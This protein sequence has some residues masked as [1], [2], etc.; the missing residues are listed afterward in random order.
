MSLQH[1]LVAAMMCIVVASADGQNL[2][3][4]PPFPLPRQC[5]SF[6]YDAFYDFQNNVTTT[7]PNVQELGGFTGSGCSRR[8]V[9]KLL[10]APAVTDPGRRRVLVDLFMDGNPTEWVFN[11]GDSSSNNGYAGDADTQW[12]DAE[13]QGKGRT[14][15]GYLSDNG[16]SGQ[17]FVVPNAYSTRQ[18]LIVGDGHIT[19]IPDNNNLIN[20]YN[21]PNLFALNGQHDDR[22]GPSNYDLFLGINRVVSQGREGSGVCK[23]GIKFLPEF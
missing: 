17:A 1:S 6:S 13:V 21:N 7:N 12:W 3:I 11:L 18:T 22:P 23:V 20:Y 19:W 16:G 15:A 4:R 8:G 10:L 5:P 9:L 2:G 14:F